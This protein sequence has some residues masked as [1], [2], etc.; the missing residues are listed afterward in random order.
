MFLLSLVPDR[1]VKDLRGRP[2]EGAQCRFDPTLHAGPTGTE[3]PDERAAR[4]AVAV[5]VCESCP[6]FAACRAAALRERPAFGV[7]G[8][9]TSAEIHAW[10]G[11]EGAPAAA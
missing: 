2:I 9:L 8:G 5:E 4:E 7:W 11:A 6:L 10:R 3:S 1:A